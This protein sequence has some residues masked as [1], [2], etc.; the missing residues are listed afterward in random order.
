VETQLIL[1]GLLRHINMTT[2]KHFLLSIISILCLVQS[3]AQCNVT[4]IIINTGYDPSTGQA[5]AIGS[6]STPVQDPHWIV[7]SATSSI[8]GAPAPG[9][10]AYT[11]PPV[12]G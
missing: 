3:Y 10:P 7:A 12:G 6:A 1:T 11:I 2:L 9:T 5:L 4:S 8:P